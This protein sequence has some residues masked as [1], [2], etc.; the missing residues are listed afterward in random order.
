MSVF[1]CIECFV[2][3]IRKEARLQAKYYYTENKIT[4]KENGDD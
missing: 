4:K 1:K 3:I 2:Y